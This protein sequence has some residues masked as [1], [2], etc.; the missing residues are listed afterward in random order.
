MLHI[1]FSIIIS[2]SSLSL[3]SKDEIKK[4]GIEPQDHEIQMVVGADDYDVF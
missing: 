3:V 4:Q 2:V 1:L